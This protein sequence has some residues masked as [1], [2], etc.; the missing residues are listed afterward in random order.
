MLKKMLLYIL[1]SASLSYASVTPTMT[2]V[3]L[4][5]GVCNFCNFWVD[6]IIKVDK[7]KAFR[8]CP[9]QTATG[10]ALLVQIDKKPNDISSIILIK[11]SSEHYSKSAAVIKIV[12]QIGIFGLVLSWLIRIFP[13]VFR[14]LVYDVIAQNRYSFL[15]MRPECRIQG[16]SEGRFLT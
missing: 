14:D 15:G 8:F 12:E 3:I 6:L 7:K 11:S 4:F 2:N 1:L 13:R 10:Q 5:D 9:L 16:P